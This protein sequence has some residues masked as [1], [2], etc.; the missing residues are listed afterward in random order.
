MS[1][2][3][4]LIK[5]IEDKIKEL[6]KKTYKTNWTCGP[7]T[8]WREGSPTPDGR[9]HRV[10]CPLWGHRG[11]PPGVWAHV[12][13]GRPSIVE[14]LLTSWARDSILT[15]FMCFILYFYHLLSSKNYIGHL[16]MNYDNLK[17]LGGFHINWKNIVIKTP[18]IKL[19]WIC[20]IKILLCVLKGLTKN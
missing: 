8:R 2:V 18:V 15:Q 14:A 1:F 6:K 12:A 11:Q 10:Y 16:C 3:E 9:G 20:S 17:K 5:W 7:P 19:L 13:H 4:G